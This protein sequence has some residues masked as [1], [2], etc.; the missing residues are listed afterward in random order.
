MSKNILITGATGFVG[1]NFTAYLQNEGLIT[2]GFSRNTTN[3][4]DISYK[5][6]TPEVWNAATA[7]V[8]LAGKAHDLKKTSKDAEYL[9]VNF[10]L[11]KSNY[12]FK[13]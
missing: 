8:H 10:E 5:E 11:A 13:G 6:L 1:L 7:M 2:L 9:E 12:K 3:P 4:N